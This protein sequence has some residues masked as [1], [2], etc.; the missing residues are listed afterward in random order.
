MLVSMATVIFFITKLFRS[1]KTLCAAFLLLIALGFLWWV[2][3][4]L[5]LWFRRAVHRLLIRRREANGRKEER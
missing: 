2:W 3:A 1:P 4:Q 5:P